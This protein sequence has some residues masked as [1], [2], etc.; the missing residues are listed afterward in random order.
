VPPLTPLSAAAVVRCVYIV[1]AAARVVSWVS[2]L[3][4]ANFTVRDL[5]LSTEKARRRDDKTHSSSLI[6]WFLHIK[7]LK[8]KALQVAPPEQTLG[9][10]RATIQHS[11]ATSTWHLPISLAF[12]C[13]IL[14]MEPICVSKPLLQLQT[15]TVTGETCEMSASLL[16][17]I[18]NDTSYEV[19]ACYL[20]WRVSCLGIGGVTVKCIHWA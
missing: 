1:K 4:G 19:Y 12:I 9:S 13:S 2:A 3:P 7:C 16:T 18:A 17:A 20:F 8:G 11:V 5:S 10:V 14:K 15:W 6:K